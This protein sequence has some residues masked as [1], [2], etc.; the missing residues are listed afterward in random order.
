MN[1]VIKGAAYI[2]AH[3]PDMVLHNG[4]TQ[5][6]E[7]IVN[8][9]SAYLQELPAHLRDYEAA[10][11]YYP[12]QTY[13]GN[14]TPEGLA[15]L[16]SSWVELKMPQA[17]RFGKFGE[18]MP[19][20]EFYMLLQ[21]CDVFN[22]VL[23][24]RDFVS[25][26]APLFRQHP[27]LSQDI[28]D[29]VQEGT[30]LE[31][32]R[33]QVDEAG[34]EPLYSDSILVGCVKRAHDIDIN[35]SAHVMLENLCSKAGGVL[36]L[37]HAVD[38]AGLAKEDI[39]Y[40]ID[41]SEEA[42]GDMN[43]RGGGNIAKACAEIAGLTQATGADVRAFCA[44]PAHALIEAASLVKAGTYKNVIV[45]AGGCTAKLGMNGKDHVKKGLPILE[46]VLG[47]FAVVVSENDGVNPEI[48]LDM[49][50]R[51]RVGTGSSPQAVISS[52]VA[53]PLE[54]R[55]LKITDIDKY[56]PEMQN[57]DVTKPA[58]AGN[59]PEANYKM[60][61][62]LAAMRGEIEKKDIM[63]FVAQHGLT[64]WAP[65]QG[66]IPSG[67]PYI[68]F[69]REAMLA[70]TVK[71]AM[72]IGK[73]SLFLGRMTNLFDGVSFV[74][75]ANL[76]PQEQEVAQNSR[77]PKIGL[78]ALGSE[79]GDEAVLA[80]AVKAAAQ[81]VNV[82]YIGTAKHP[83]VTT[84]EA[85]DEQAAHTAME[86]LLA[87]GQADGAVT[88]HYPFPIGVSTV[89][90]IPT[91][92]Q[93][94]EMFIATTTGTSATERTEALIRNTLA[95]IAAAKASGVEQPSVGIL[96]IDGARQCQG[97]LQ[98]LQENGYAIRFASSDRADGGCVMRGNDVLSGAADVLVTDSLTGNI[99][100]K[101]LSAYS[102]GGGYETVGYGYGPGLGPDYE[103][104]IHIISRASGAPVIAN[105]I[106]YAAEMARGQVTAQLKQE[107]AAADKA[108]LAAIL[109]ARKGGPDQ[110]QT[111]QPAAAE[112]KAPP[113]E[114]ITAS[115]AGVEVMDIEDAVLALWAAGVYAQ[116]GMGC[117][118]PIIQVSEANLSRA[119]DI[120]TQAGYIA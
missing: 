81:G 18:L 47:G 71:T 107:Y 79:H 37:L 22:V 15:E 7:R 82:Y 23:L 54:K 93:G 26:T 87:S 1:S 44:G 14:L 5:T 102:S 100:L 42:C 85:A 8:P 52:L 96:N 13:I 63:A 99:L 103:R 6:T 29:R 120:L 116:G 109:A 69:A 61:A 68:G 115:I 19:Q 27:L 28:L 62:A 16:G 25:R 35:L 65:T 64:G 41:C 89:G 104:L 88:M 58:G 106:L 53:A 10:L 119:K 105:A 50:G 80:G 20:D 66:H 21:V 4:S 30:D 98:R 78:T 73:G 34:A 48:N 110:A 90:R 112:I 86:Q 17:S 70:G 84:V 46:D 72:I 33:R 111:P 11:A 57:P 92:A 97:A 39:D 32:I 3:T 83:A 40:V 108:G 101:M 113:A 38:K 118:G 55:G 114:I 31:D 91:P 94:K 76:G 24:E 56:S 12:N 117:T 43:Q 77:I 95:G 49:V 74:M 2:L 60:I 67:V 75:Q 51:H 59:V 36:A 9:D 45:S